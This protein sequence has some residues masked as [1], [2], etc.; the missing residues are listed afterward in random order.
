M[1]IPTPTEFRATHGDPTDWAW[2]EYETQ[3]NLA[4][5][6]AANPYICWFCGAE[7]SPNVSTCG[8]CNHR[9]DDA[10]TTPAP[11]PVRPAA[12]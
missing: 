4:E 2:D 12:A 3:L 11:A 6:N 8:F 9:A 1:A 5:I 7:N 10:P